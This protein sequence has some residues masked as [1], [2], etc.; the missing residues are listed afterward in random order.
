MF[1][2][3]RWTR[4][5]RH[6]MANRSAFAT[7]DC[8]SATVGSTPTGASVPALR[9]GH[10][11]GQ[12]AAGVLRPRTFLT[13]R[14]KRRVITTADFG[15]SIETVYHVVGVTAVS[16]CAARSRKKEQIVHCSGRIRDVARS[17]AGK[18]GR[19]HSHV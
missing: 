9:A 16:V 5:T 8:K 14:T 17:P 18:D 7:A 4:G 13:A 1:S 15:L 3:R 10:G 6:Y 11:R 2:K 19:G 12:K